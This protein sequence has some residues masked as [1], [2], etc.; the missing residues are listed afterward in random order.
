MY[1]ELYTTITILITSQI[2]FLVVCEHRNNHG[3]LA[4]RAVSE[5]LRETGDWKKF[6]K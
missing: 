2:W 4:L 1:Q 5:S 3:D 6:K